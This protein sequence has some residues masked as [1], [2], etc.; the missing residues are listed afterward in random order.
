MINTNLDLVVPIRSL[1]SFSF[2]SL[3]IVS[4]E[5][6]MIFVCISRTSF[7]FRSWRR[8]SYPSAPGR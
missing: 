6:W 1:E 7:L 2:C 3:T 8:M 5:G 4:N